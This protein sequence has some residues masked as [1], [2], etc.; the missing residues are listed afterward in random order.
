[1]RSVRRRLSR[2]PQCDAQAIEYLESFGA[3]GHGASVRAC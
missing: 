3:G 2:V 1:L